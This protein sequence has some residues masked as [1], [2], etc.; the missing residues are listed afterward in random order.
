ME[1]RKNVCVFGRFVIVEGQGARMAELLFFRDGELQMR[2]GLRGD[3]TVIGRGPQSD[4][5]IPD[6]TISRKQC[7]IVRRGD[8]Y[9]LLDASGHGTAVSRRQATAHGTGLRDGDEIHLGGFSIV[10]SAAPRPALVE[11]TA[12]AAQRRRR[13]G[14]HR[15]GPLVAIRTRL[16]VPRPEGESVIPLRTEEGFSI[17]IGSDPSGALQLALKDDFV[18][19][20][21][22]RISWQDER[23]LIA[24]L[25]SSNGTFVD[26]VRV[27]AA[28]L[29]GRHAIRAGETTVW[30]EQEFADDGR[31]QPLPG[32]VSRDPLMTPVIEM[33]R[34]I[35]PSLV[36]VAIHGET[37][38]G[39]EIVARAIHNL[40]PRREGPFV[41]LNC[42]AL[43]RE[44]VE[45]ELFGHEKG[46]FTGADTARTGA[47][48][49]ADGGTLFLDEIGELP[50]SI[51]VKLLRTIER[52]EVRRLGGSRTET[53]SVRIIS[54]TH[55][56]L[57]GAVE[58]GSFRED[59]YYRLCVA[60]V[61]IPPLRQRPG[62]IVALAEHFAGTLTAGQGNIVL[63]AAARTKLEA[64]S[65]P[66]NAR[67]LRNAMQLA[68]LNRTSNTITDEDISLRPAPVQ[69]R[70]PDSIKLG[71]RSIDDLERE[72]YR[73]ALDRNA[74]DKRAAME[75]LGVP[76]ST[77]FRKIDEFGFTR[78]NWANRD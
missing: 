74:G 43:P 39:K 53:V 71:G 9:V 51:Q 54:A 35:A 50:L 17:T 27:L 6:R 76:R 65:W 15:A 69:R 21:H 23:W 42:G 25:K 18:S 72:A 19:A 10:Y 5:V 49:E 70:V 1:R 32:L 33:V 48:T 55:R 29:S 73:L 28:V 44:T 38:V 67:E 4:F 31:E 62:D 8:G 14:V 47:F 34:R 20:E 26:N 64:H 16:R 30:F 45:S 60:P 58:S 63:T 24:D 36:P 59:L 57:A 11:A 78:G 41:A 12:P 46:A 77:F 13:T 61:E 40:S 68:L 52:G 7:E 75:E 2:A 56:D 3:R 37:G 22:C 66:G